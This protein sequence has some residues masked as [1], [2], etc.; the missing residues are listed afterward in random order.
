MIIVSIGCSKD[1]TGKNECYNKLTSP[2][3]TQ[4]GYTFS[5]GENSV[6]GTLRITS[7]DK[8]SIEILTPD[9][10]SGIS[11]QSEISDNETAYSISYS[12]I[13]ASVSKQI[14]GKIDLIFMLV[15]QS[16]A[17]QIKN[18]DKS[19]IIPSSETFEIEGLKNTVPYTTTF[20]DDDVYFDLTYDSVTGTPLAFTA[21]SG[22]DCVSLVF[23]KFKSEN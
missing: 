19:N 1:T 5:K 23:Q 17:N 10:L 13:N 3:I 20:N 14:L 18:Q 6:V 2:F 22:D 12:D 8:C 9:I 4:A 16:V 11:A 21:K 7:T 15:S